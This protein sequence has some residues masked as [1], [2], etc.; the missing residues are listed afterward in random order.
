MILLKKLGLFAAGAWL[1]YGILTGVFGLYCIVAGHDV[2]EM[3]YGG[4]AS[5]LLALAAG[6]MLAIWAP[7]LRRRRS[8]PT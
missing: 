4:F 5:I 1:A 2:L 6:A 3:M 7:E 8:E